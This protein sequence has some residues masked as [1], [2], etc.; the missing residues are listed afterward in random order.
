MKK[1]VI[2]AAIISV[3]S[4]IFTVSAVLAVTGAVSDIEISV[5][6][7][8][9]PDSAGNIIMRAFTEIGQV[10]TVIGVVALLLL[11]PSRLRVGMPVAVT[12][13]S[14][15]LLN[16]GIKNLVCRIRPEHR[17]LS[18]SGY[19]FPSG[20]AMNS[21]ALYTALIV[22]LLRFCKSKKEKAAVCIIWILPLFIGIS[23]VYFNVHYLTDVTAG[24]SA[25]TVIG[26]VVSSL[27]LSFIDK[28]QG[29]D[30]KCR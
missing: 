5:S 7:F 6:K 13:V 21:A 15:W 9:N 8:L 30:K 16:T 12:T 14:S 10:Y 2:L 19:S 17:L 29:V 28:K 22:C 23:R 1:K 4:L 3:M 25:G 20:H 27:M 11:L 24:L 18:V 26:I